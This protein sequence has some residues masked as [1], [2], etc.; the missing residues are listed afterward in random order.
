MNER[1]LGPKRPQYIHGQTVP[2]RK[3]TKISRD[4]ELEAFGGVESSPSAARGIAEALGA[5]ACQDISTDFV[6]H[7]GSERIPECEDLSSDSRL[8]P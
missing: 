2:E 7:C 3:W 4:F 8:V 1:W 5:K 6:E